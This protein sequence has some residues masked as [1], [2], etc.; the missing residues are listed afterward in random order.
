MGKYNK[1]LVNE[2]ADWVRENGLIEYGGA[3]LGDF[4]SHFGIDDM[5]Y[6]RWL[7]QSEFAVAIK[8]AKEDFK[9]NLEKDIVSSLSKAAKGYDYEQVTTE[10][11]EVQE[12][13]KKVFK[14]VKQ[15]RKTIHVECNVGAA[16]FLLTNIAPDSWK[17]RQ[18]T[19]N[20][21]KG[22]IDIIIG[23]E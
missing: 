23:D 14:A 8:K 16:I 1:E 6:Y 13:D 3:K 10:G 22:D 17:N 9:N 21:I 4:L 18:D 5:T 2:M 19:T 7:K 11:R 20:M 12:G 15:V